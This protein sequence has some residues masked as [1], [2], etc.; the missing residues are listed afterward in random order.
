MRGVYTCRRY[1]VT[2][3]C[4]NSGSTGWSGEGFCAANF[5]VCESPEVSLFD[6][7]RERA[8]TRGDLEV[9]GAVI[10]SSL[11]VRCLEFW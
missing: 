9:E 3:H 4:G 11:E 1:H 5:P 10:S 7:H 2:H 8:D 6:Y